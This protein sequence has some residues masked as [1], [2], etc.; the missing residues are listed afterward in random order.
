MENGQIFLYD[1]STNGVFVNNESYTNTSVELREGDRLGIGYPVTEEN[2]HN[3]AYYGFVLER[4]KIKQELK[5]E[6]TYDEYEGSNDCFNI[7]SKANR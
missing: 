2:A 4:V 6:I 5:Q 7:N 3:K 1:S